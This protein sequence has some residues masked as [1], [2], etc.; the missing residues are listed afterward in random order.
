MTIQE[1]REDLIKKIK[2]ENWDIIVIGGGITGAGI[3]REAVR[4]NLKV[5]LLEQRD[6]AWG[7]SSRST[8]MVHGGLRYL[9]EG[10]FALTRESVIERENLIN[11]L[12]GL[13][14][15]KGF[16]LPFYKEKL[17]QRLTI[18]IG[19]IIY[20]F[21]A[22]QWRKH[23]YSLKEMEKLAPLVGKKD[24][25][26]G[27]CIND[28]VTDDARLVFRVL[29]E[30]LEQGATALNYCQVEHVIKEDNKV[31]GVV[32]KDRETGETLN[33]NT[34]LVIN[35]TGA[36]AD[37][38][39]GEVKKSNRDK[40]RPLRGS[41]IILSAEKLP[42]VDNISMIHPV[43]KR[44]VT[45]LAWEG[46]V[47]MGT[48]DIDHPE[49]LN[50]EASISPEEVQYLLDALNHQ[51]PNLDLTSEDIISTMAG[52]RPVIDTGKENPS[53]ES[54][55]HVIWQEEGLLTVTGGKLTTFRII[56]LD[57]LKAAQ[58]IIGPLPD[59]KKKQAMFS[60]TIMPATIP[61]ELS[62][63]Q[64][65]RLQGRYGRHMEAL[66]AN[67]GKDELEQVPGTDTIWAEFRWAAGNEFVTHLD[68][69]LLRRTRVGLLIKQGGKEILP[70]VR[71]ICQTVLEWSNE[72]WE[73]EEKN[74]LD[75]WQ[76]HYSVPGK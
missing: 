34:K 69:L 38:L 43:D 37:K 4:R 6:F 33:L 5:L 21:L 22:W 59:L 63:E 17:F 50:V 20:D 64:L 32:V 27:F 74:Y 70:R 71:E 61:P 72:Q 46:R 49:D 42:L 25:K 16:I 53:E 15:N 57:A 60:K 10:D 68:D 44:P 75:L 66:I 55:D 2:S 76:K 47:V 11:E 51:F 18:H 54:R 24:L 3:L 13:V 35:A 36:W 31:C 45:T 73:K 56:A 30:A 14:T 19:L 48:T 41:H 8:K 9:K 67:A 26:G 7:T 52:I 23:V 65:L 39:R 29:S 40:V 28:A 58:A 12:P 1:S 62:E